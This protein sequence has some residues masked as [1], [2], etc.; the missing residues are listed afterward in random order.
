MNYSN[1]GKVNRRTPGK[2]NRKNK[3]RVAPN[4]RPHIINGKKYSQGGTLRNK[5]NKG[6]RTSVGNMRRSMNKGNGSI[7]SPTE[8]PKYNCCTGIPCPND[9]KCMGSR[10]LCWCVNR[11]TV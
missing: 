9:M 3:Q 1:G 10:P 11:G 8:K 2:T 7:P 4:G 5:M 6:Q